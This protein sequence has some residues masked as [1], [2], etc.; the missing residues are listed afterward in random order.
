MHTYIHAYMHTCIH[1]CMHT[2]MHACMHAYIHIYVHT[3][4]HTYTHAYGRGSV[5]MHRMLTGLATH[6]RHKRVTECCHHH[7]SRE[8]ERE[9]ERR[10]GRGRDWERERGRGRG[11][12]GERET[13]LG[14]A[15]QSA[16]VTARLSFNDT[17]STIVITQTALSSK[18]GTVVSAPWHLILGCRRRM[19][20]CL[21]WL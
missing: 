4:M 19:A 21:S 18:H 6:Q 3:Y 15:S 11:R 16:V 20:L 14:N 17:A 8:T 10:R 2:C 5:R 7:D 9:R 13:L 12:G 1:A